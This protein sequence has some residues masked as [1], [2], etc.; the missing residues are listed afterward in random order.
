MRRC[1]SPSATETRDAGEHQFRNVA[2]DDF[3]FPFPFPETFTQRIVKKI[4]RPSGDDQNRPRA[5]DSG[6]GL[7][8][9]EKGPG[10]FSYGADRA[11]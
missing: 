8:G 11:P 7:H 4:T 10:Y 2:K 5:P 3:R 1:S 6:F 9:A